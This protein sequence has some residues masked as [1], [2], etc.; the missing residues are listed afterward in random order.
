MTPHRAA[1]RLQAFTLAVAAASACRSEAPREDT[2]LGGAASGDTQLV[3][4]GDRGRWAASPRLVHELRIGQ[5]EGDDRYQFGSVGGLAVGEDGTIFVVDAQGPR[6]RMF[7]A[8][9]RFVGEIGRV[10][11]G[12]G[13]Y[14]HITRMAVTAAGEL[15]IY[16]TILRRVS[17]FSPTGE[18]LRSFDSRVGGNWRRNSFHQDAAG[19]FFIFGVRPSPGAPVMIGPDGTRI[20]SEGP[21]HQISF[22]LKLSPDQPREKR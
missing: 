21:G 22:Y 14:R 19:N 15:A 12:P 20:G 18:F 17:F 8:G 3:V 5:L 13:E 16:D 9:G 7:D 1:L 6:L 10:G 2:A 4:S 11:A